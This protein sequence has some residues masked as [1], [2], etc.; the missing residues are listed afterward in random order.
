MTTALFYEDLT[1]GMTFVTGARTIV[2]D[3]FLTFAKV[4]GD[5]HPIHVDAEYAARTEFG[6]R[7]GHGPFG[8][9]MAIGLFGQISELKESAI[10]MLD[11]GNWAFRAPIFIG[12]S[13]HMEL[14]ITE[15]R[16]TRSGRGVVGRHFRLIKHDGTVPQEG[17]SAMIVRRREDAR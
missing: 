9:A 5:N 15:K 13:I 3:D 12:D 8:I 17:D 10:L 1:P 16:L 7:I 4:S 11:I 6:Q 14:T 2:E